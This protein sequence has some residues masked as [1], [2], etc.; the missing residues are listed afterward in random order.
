MRGELPRAGA[1][2]MLAP[3]VLLLIRL[4]ATLDSLPNIK[5]YAETMKVRPRPGMGPCG[6]SQEC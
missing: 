3:Y 4:E 2:A 5:R 6:I 1:D